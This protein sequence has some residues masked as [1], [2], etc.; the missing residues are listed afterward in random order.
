MKFLL[1]FSLLFSPLLPA[2]DIIKMR[3]VLFPADPKQNYKYQLID[4][5]LKTTQEKF[6]PYQITFANTIHSQKRDITLLNSGAINV[7]ISMTS[8]EREKRMQAVRYPVLKGLYGYRV[9]L[10]RKEDQQRF[11]NIQS[12]DELKQLKAIQ[13]A[14]W[15]DLTVLKANNLLAEGASRH[16]SLYKMLQYGRVDYFP[17]RIHEPWVELKNHPNMGLAVEKSIVL[18]YPAPGYIFVEKGNTHLAERL[19]EGFEQIIHSGVFD[20]FF[21]QHPQIIEMKENANLQIRVIFILANPLLT[22]ET[23]LNDKRL[24][25]QIH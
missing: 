3:P 2:L 17:R 23:P 14:Q 6:G 15:P 10:I 22:K 7:F 5:I 9:F 20:R 12:L 13:G 18:Y 16:D 24:W 1:L 19:N 11:S 21:N 4:L 25:Y 8:K